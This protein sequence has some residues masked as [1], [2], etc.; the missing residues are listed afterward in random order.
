[1]SS[2][3][4]ELKGKILGLGLTNDFGDHVYSGDDVEHGKPAPDLFLLAA[5]KLG[6]EPA[7]CIVI[8]DSRHGVSAGVA[9]GMTVWGFVRGPHCH[10][11]QAD[12]LAQH[13]AARI[14]KH[15]D[16]IAVA[17]RTL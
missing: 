13:G 1:S 7:R 2:P 11:G 6:I 15:M 17:L 8:E 3:G 12:L 16:E 14:F 4:H 5:A 10:A 9:A